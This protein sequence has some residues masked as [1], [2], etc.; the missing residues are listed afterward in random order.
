MKES[1]WKQ[2]R[3]FSESGQQEAVVTF[4]LPKKDYKSFS[5]EITFLQ[6]PLTCRLIRIELDN[7]EFEVLCTSLLDPQLYEYDQFEA[8]YHLRW[9]EEESYKLL[10][11]R[12]EVEDFSGK[13]ER[14]VRQDFHAKILLMTLC[15]A[16]AHPIDEKVKKEFV[17]DRERKHAQQI[18]RTQALA[19]TKELLISLFL[20]GEFQKAIR[21]FDE[22]VYKTREIVR[23]DRKVERKMKPKRPFRMN[24]KQL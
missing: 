7:G 2:I 14:A 9:S 4:H 6:S 23:P 12:I 20:K 21:C 22:M 16:F 15:A 10:K 11:A 17:A 3:S 5:A 8:L 13:T 18:N 1:W 24:Y 19:T